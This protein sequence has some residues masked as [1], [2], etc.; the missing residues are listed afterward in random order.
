MTI[1][2][3][4]FIGVFAF[5]AVLFTVA[6]TKETLD[7]I[8]SDANIVAV[9]ELVTFS[10]PTN[11]TKSKLTD[12]PVSGPMSPDS[13]GNGHGHGHGWGRGRGSHPGR[14]VGD[15]IAFTGL[16]SAAQTYLLANSDTS[17]IVRIAKI[18]LSDGTIQYSVRF[19]TRKHLHFD[20]A[21]VVIITTTHNHVFTNIL[22]TDLPAAAQTYLAANVI[23]ANIV[24]II[25]VTSTDGTITYGVRMADNTRYTF[26]TAGAVIPNPKGGRRGRH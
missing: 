25:K 15:S 13:V 5:A 10:D 7:T 12:E 22:I 21:G 3:K 8:V 19:S 20:A 23:A 1:N 6:C 26:D 14:I 4:N 24:G 17:T 9:D 16:P 18:T 11:S 2:L